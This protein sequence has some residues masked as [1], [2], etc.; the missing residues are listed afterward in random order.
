MRFAG[1]ILISEVLHRD[2]RWM[3]KRRRLWSSWNYLK[4][5]GGAESELCVTYWMNELQELKT[6]TN[7]FVT[8]NPFDEIHPKA[9]EAQFEYDHPVFD[10]ATAR[11][12]KD[13]W[14]LQGT[15]RTWFCG[16]YFGYGFHEDGI[17][18]G[19]A[20]A[21]QLGGVSRPWDLENPSGRI[22]SAPMTTRIEAAE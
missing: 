4:R 5:G 15:K 6:G 18:S 7:L 12:Q 9:V 10:N 8:L 21:E 1:A 3:P 14:A 2:H 19:L 16:A 20:V 11:A 17:Q 13:L 22:A